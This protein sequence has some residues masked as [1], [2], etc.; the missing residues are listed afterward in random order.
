MWVSTSS[1][2]ETSVAMPTIERQSGRLGVISQ[3][4]TVSLILCHSVKSSP[5]GVSSGKIMMPLWSSPSPSSRLEQFMPQESTPRSLPFLIVTPPGSVAPMRAVTVLSPCSKFWAPQTTWRGTD[6][7]V[8][9][10]L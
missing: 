6:L 10:V 8:A 4:I 5:T 2:A 1:T 7:P 3:S 9:S